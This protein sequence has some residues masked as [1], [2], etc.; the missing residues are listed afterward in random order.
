MVNE[1]MH[2]IDSAFIIQ[3][4]LDSS[5][6]EQEDIKEILEDMDKTEESIHHFL[7]HLATI[8]VMG[9]SKM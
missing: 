4:I 3:E 9:N 6:E 2:L 5:P 8:Y 7:K 1:T